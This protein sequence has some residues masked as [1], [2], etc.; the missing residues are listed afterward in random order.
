MKNLFLLFL[1]LMFA[2]IVNAQNKVSTSR[3]QMIQSEMQRYQQKA[4][5][6]E[7]LLFNGDNYDVNYYR[8]SVRLN[9]DSNKYVKGSVTTYFT[10][11]QSN[12]TDIAFD[13]ASPL[14]YTSVK[15]HGSNLAAGKINNAGDNLTIT[16]PNIPVSGTLDSVTVFYQ[17]VPP[18]VPF[19]GNGTGFVKST[20]GSPAKAWLRMIRQI[21]WI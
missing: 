20:H 16:L 18:V 2:T 7:G 3:S 10:T 13:M 12:V 6:P 5:Q 21:Q 14:F 4:N 8:L 9:P 17:G 11:T 19:F 15:Y 1:F